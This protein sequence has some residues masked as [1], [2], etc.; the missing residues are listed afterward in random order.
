[1]PRPLRTGLFLLVAFALACRGGEA[2]PSQP[3]A[4][5]PDPGETDGAD[6]ADGDDGTTDTGDP[7]WGLDQR[8][9]NPTCHAP[10]RP[11]L[12]SA[13]VT[14]ELAWPALS[15]YRPT[16]L[17]H[18]PGDDSRWYV[19]ESEGII[20]V[21]DD[22]PAVS[23]ADVFVDLEDR[24]VGQLEG[25]GEMGLLGMAFHPDFST[26]GEVLLSYTTGEVG[27]FV[28]RVSRFVS[29]D[30][31]R[32]LDPDSEE[33][34]LTHPQVNH[35]HNGG[36]IVFGPDG[37]LWIAFGDGGTS[38]GQD[39]A[40]DLQR[41]N[42]KLLRIDV[43]GGDPYAI[44][45]DNPDPTGAA[46]APE[47]W[48]WGL[49]NPW[50]WSFDSATG[51]L[52]LGDVGSDVVEEVN[53]IEK[54]G[55]YGW[56]CCEG[57]E[58]R[59]WW[60]E[61]RDRDMLE[62]VYA[63]PH[64][65]GQAVI[66]GA[67][68][69]G[70][71]LPA[72]RGTLVF[73]DFQAGWLRGLSYDDTGA[74]QVETLIEGLPLLVSGFAEDL[75]GE[76]YV[77]AFSGVGQVYRLV[78]AED[79]G[80]TGDAAGEPFPQTLAETGCLDPA[81]PTQPADGLIPYDL[82]APFWSDGLDKQR[83]FA[84]P[85]GATIT[86]EEDGRWTLPVGSVV[87]KAFRQDE[88][89]VETRLMVRHDDGGW[90]GYTY[91]W[92]DG[93]A[94]LVSHGQRLDLDGQPYAVPTGWQCLACHREESGRTLGLETAQL[95]REVTYPGGRVA[96]Q[97][98]TLQ[99]IGV[100]DGVPDAAPLVDPSDADAPVADRARVWLHTNCASCHRAGAAG[101][102]ALDLRWQTPLAETGACDV[103]PTAGNLGLDDPRLLAPGHPERSVLLQRVRTDGVGR[104]PPMGSLVVDAQGAAL[105]EAWIAGLE[106]CEEGR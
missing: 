50:G 17:V 105:L 47:V 11:P 58:C 40:I 75:A 6:G 67:V 78:P 18:P 65:A 24:V 88:Q 30:G 91:V 36:R 8:P 61:C 42:G 94:R 102:G 14:L 98:L 86:V 79:E 23:S 59:D 9:A 33:I 83:W 16:N 27:A 29:R 3:P 74:P 53:R 84:L 7:P 69:Q 87:V 34:L 46:V 72:L 13:G 57:D 106:G 44:P 63:Y 95:A 48:A 76:L 80:D 15:F 2:D 37:M 66:V 62:P 28:S 25:G 82:N 45:P 19:T 41:F 101:T 70:D 5:D 39:A 60:V 77:V 92:Q 38:A 26:N 1:M 90:A 96:D 100:V 104:M 52:W 35:N 12:E 85:D 68:Y 64:A 4:G 22:D 73:G 89:P 49:R 10:A 54:G 99:H 31:G 32:T 55:N 51:D 43:D 81:D 56:P 97:L 103:A 20:Y 71:A 21:F 93:E